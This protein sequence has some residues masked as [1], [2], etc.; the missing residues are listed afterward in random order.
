MPPTA[1]RR[2]SMQQQF[3]SQIDMEEHPFV[4]DTSDV[5]VA[6]RFERI[7]SSV[8]QMNVEGKRLAFTVLIL[9]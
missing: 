5:P 3:Q 6:Q 7:L 2:L 8:R 1:S 9:L 4:S